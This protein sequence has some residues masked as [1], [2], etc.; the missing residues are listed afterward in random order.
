MFM[1]KRLLLM[2][3]M[4]VFVGTMVSG[5]VCMAMF[6]FAGLMSMFVRMFM[7]VGMFVLVAVLMFMGFFTMDVLMFVLMLVRMEMFMFMG[8]F[9][10]HF[11]SP[12]KRTL[13]YKMV[14][15]TAIHLQA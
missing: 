8:M 12:F 7:A 9:G 14:V 15:F 1:L 6:L 2:L 13:Y 3:H 10:F 4:L 11:F 5:V